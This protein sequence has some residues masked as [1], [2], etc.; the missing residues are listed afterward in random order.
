MKTVTMLKV[1]NS[2]SVAGVGYLCECEYLFIKFSSGVIYEYV[3]V[4]EV[5]YTDLVKLVVLGNM[6]TKSPV[7]KFIQDH[8]KG[9]YQFEKVTQPSTEYGFIT[10]EGE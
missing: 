9:A 10:G 3:D 8:I 1:L 4:P 7:G 2:S 5:V 6:G